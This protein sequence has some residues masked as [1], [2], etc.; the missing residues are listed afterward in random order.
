M[1]RKNV[2]VLQEE[3]SDCGVCSLLSI[4]KYY[5]GYESLE[6]LRIDSLTTSKGVSAYNLIECAKKHGFDCV[7]KKIDD[8]ENEILPY[9]AHI[10]INNTLSH[11][12][13]VYEITEKFV[14]I[15]DPAVGLIKKDVME[16][17][18]DFTGVIIDLFPKEKLIKKHIKNILWQNILAELKKQ[19]L[20]LFL[21]II[22]NIIL[23][24]LS[25]INS[26]YVSLYNNKFILILI[27]FFICI[28]IQL[29]EYLINILNIEINRKT[30][31]NIYENYLNHLFLIPL[32]ILHLKD[33]GEIIKR[34]NELSEVEYT[35][36]NFFLELMLSSI[37]IFS[38]ICALTF[39]KFQLSLF[40]L[41]MFLIVVLV[42]IRCYKKLSYKINEYMYASTDYN[43]YLHSYLNSFYSVKHMN[44]IKYVKDI[45]NDKY[46]S[47]SSINATLLK[48]VSQIELIKKVFL[49]VSEFVILTYLLVKSFN[50]SFSYENVIVIYFIINYLFSSFNSVINLLPSFIIQKKVIRKINEFYNISLKVDGGDAFK[51]G[52][53]K[54]ENVS[55]SYNNYK[56]TIDSLSF[57][58]KMHEHV[59]ITGESGS[60]K[61]TIMK[62]INKEYE[63]YEGTISIGNKNI[64]D[65]DESSYRENVEYL[66]QEESFINGTIKDNILFG[67]KTS[68]EELNRV[69]K[70][71]K[72]DSIVEKYPLKLET[73]ISSNN[74]PL[75]GGEK[76]LIILARGLLKRK[77]IIIIDEVL[78]ELDLSLETEVLKNIDQNINS[79][80][81]YITHKNVDVFKKILSV[82]KE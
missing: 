59:R 66:S 41:V 3:V 17:K 42:M 9:I 15:M 6:N 25:F 69:I 50:G 36:T 52:N 26:Y 2:E 31:N 61:S 18:S 49:G 23:V 57:E 44:A 56:K 1:I 60:G 67:R 79:T 13:V 4:I 58:I 16:F 30:G 48:S 24:I 72:I 54:F 34:T 43:N 21:I 29:I 22:L 39:I 27:F 38:L 55:F 74:N 46:K 78:S 75:S 65:I 77:S 81:I 14:L 62:L 40:I 68:E 35:V 11:F 63:N 51:Q 64:K 20:K 10:K 73:Y 19:K 7:G 47:F 5:G 33:N 8:I 28:F 76:G 70:I 37:Y 71:C 32:R 80:I 45:L 12:V 82:R 53:I